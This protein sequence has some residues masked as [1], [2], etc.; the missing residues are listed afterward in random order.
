VTESLPPGQADMK[1]SGYNK[2]ASLLAIPH[3]DQIQNKAVLDILDYVQSIDQLEDWE[4]VK[5]EDLLTIKKRTGSKYEKDLIVSRLE[6]YFEFKVDL[7]LVLD[8]IN[9]DE[10][11]TKWDKNFFEFRNVERNDYSEYL[12][13]SAFKVL[14]YKTEYV[15]KKFI[16]VWQDQ[17]FI[18]VYSVD[19]PKCPIGDVNRAHTYFSVIK[20]FLDDDKTGIVVY[21]QTDPKNRLA[22]MATGVAIPKLSDWANKL[23][24]QVNKIMGT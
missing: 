5:H 19:H 6:F 1:Q 8:L 15:E 12:L 9:S 13:Y 16:L 3:K 17:V 23:K 21:N 7:K 22:R 20:V 4:L 10:W 14:T 24:N 11:R 18:V 2:E